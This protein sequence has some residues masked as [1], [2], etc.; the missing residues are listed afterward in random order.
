[1][2]LLLEKQID[3]EVK[4]LDPDLF[5]D[6]QWFEGSVFYLI[7]YN[8]GSGQEPLIA[9][10]WPELSMSMVDAL[11]AQEGDIT[12]AI[13]QVKVNN[14]AKRELMRQERDQ[15]IEE[16]AKEFHKLEKTDHWRSLPR[17]QRRKNPHLRNR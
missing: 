3:R 4:K 13:K 5:L 17:E 16:A 15:A 2:D 6:K 12:E 11:K 14:A 8:I 10:A 7:K 9:L 1:M